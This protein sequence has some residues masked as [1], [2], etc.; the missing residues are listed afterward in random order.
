MGILHRIDLSDDVPSYAEFSGLHPKTR[1]PWAESFVLAAA[2]P[3]TAIEPIYG[4]IGATADGRLTYNVYAMRGLMRSLLVDDEDRARWDD[5][6][7]DPARQIPAADF[8]LEVQ[9]VMADLLD[10]PFGLRSS[11]SESPPAAPDSA[12]TAEAS[13]SAAGSAPTTLTPDPG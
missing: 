8:A 2:I 13:S 4:A 9:S 3:Q 10:V 11:S 5:L 7:A 1:E 12:D 6:M